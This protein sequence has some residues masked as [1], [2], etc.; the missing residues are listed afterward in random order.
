MEKIKVLDFEKEIINKYLD[1][2]RFKEFLRENPNVE[3]ELDY[4]NLQ[5]KDLSE[6]DLDI[7]G[8]ESVLDYLEEVASIVSSEEKDFVVSSLPLVAQIAFY[9]LRE[10][11]AYLDVVQEGT[12]GLIKAMENYDSDK[13]QDL[14][15]YKK[16]WIIR[17]I[18]IY[19]HE[20]IKDIQNEF[21]SFFKNKKENF[22]VE[23]EEE[24]S[25]DNSEIFLTEKDL[26]P[27]I[28]AI[29]KREKLAERM[30]EFSYLKNRLSQR[31]ITVLNY[32]FGFGVDRRYSIFEIEEKLKL[33]SG[34]G[35]KIFEQALV[36]LST[37]EGKFFL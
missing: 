37:M 18:V 3:I 6:E 24:K 17:E 30:I 15:S 20:K 19:I 32:Y 2:E 9:Y 21:K 1:E 12:I 26:L 23:V 29:E 31:Q 33:N 22:G 34:D 16:M 28:E 14:E 11:V 35:E 36:I 8:E 7:L 4:S 25:E 13:Y 5:F 27:N 10:C